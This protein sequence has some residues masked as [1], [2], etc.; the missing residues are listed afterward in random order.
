MIF[1]IKGL[2]GVKASDKS[3]AKSKISNVDGALFA[4]LL[5]NAQAT[6]QTPNEHGVVSD[7]GLPSG[8]IP[9]EDHL[10]RDAKGQAREMLKTLQSIAQDALSGAPVEATQRLQQ[11]SE[12][13]DAVPMQDLNDDQKRVLDELRTR[14]A[15]ETAKLKS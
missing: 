6:Q 9:V 3:K 2:G 11:L 10:P 15:V 7:L 1:D 8:F 13:S 12:Q 14:A 5:E 4:D